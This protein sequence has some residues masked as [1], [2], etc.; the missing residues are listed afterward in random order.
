MEL[1]EKI[2]FETEEMFLSYGI[3]SVTMDDIA[4]ELGIS[5]KTLYQFVENKADLIQQIFHE[6][7][8]R[9]MEAMMEIRASAKN[10]I[11]EMIQI[12]RYVSQMLRKM[13]PTVI[14]DLRKY[15]RKSFEL[16]ESLHQQFIYGIIKENIEQGIKQKIYRKEIDVEIISK[17]Y[18]ATS[19]LVVDDKIF[20]MKD[21]N[22]EQLYWEFIKYH[23]NGIASSKGLEL[24]QQYSG[25]RSQ[26]K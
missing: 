15:Y 8:K 20:S 21:Y 22:R 17:L 4:K 26:Q 1:R 2:L 9:E 12:A 13:G 16:M 10:A 19:F 14:Y 11:D 6:H 18:V 24:L 23:I 3:K 5:K 25:T 7:S